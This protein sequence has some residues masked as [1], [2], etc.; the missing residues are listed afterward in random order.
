MR[1][2]NV[3]MNL[4]HHL[5]QTCS[6]NIA[7]WF[8]YHINVRCKP[9]IPNAMKKQITDTKNARDK[10][11]LISYLNVSVFLTSERQ[12]ERAPHA[13][14]E[15]CDESDGAGISIRPCECNGDMRMSLF[16]PVS[17]GLAEVGPGPWLLA[18]A[19]SSSKFY[20]EP[21][22]VRNSFDADA[23]TTN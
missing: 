20:D 11:S 19:G 5:L 8:A 23:S 2:T 9:S 17:L 7:K 21:K 6:K 12:P 22:E 16:S 3:D 14:V 10:S 1:S 15:F 13:L 18:V 4:L